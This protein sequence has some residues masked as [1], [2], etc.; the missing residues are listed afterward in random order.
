MT[1]SL[2]DKRSTRD[3]S[4]VDGFRLVADAYIFGYPLVLMDV[5]R[6]VATSVPHVTDSRAPVNQF[7][8]MRAFP[9]PAFTDVVSPNADT[10]YSTAWLDLSAGPM[11]LSL[12]EM[13]DRYYVMPLLDAWTNVF[14]CPGTRTTGGR[15]SDFVITG[16]QWSGA[17]HH[18][19]RE[20]RS[21]TSMALLIGRT[22]TN[23]EADYDAVHAIQDH[24]CL[25]PLSAWGT[26]RHAPTPLGELFTDPA[27]D[28]RTP[29][30]E[31]VAKMDGATFFSKLNALM[32]SNRPAPVDAAAIERFATIG[33]GP[34]KPLDA[35]AW[36]PAFDVGARNGQARIIDE[37]AKPQ[38]R[39]VNGWD[40]PP[41][42]LGRFGTEYLLR[43]VIALV[44]LGAN[45]PEDAVYPHATRDSEGRPLSGTKK[46]IVRFRKGELPPVRAFWS[47]TM[48]DAKQR[49]VEN[50]IARYAIGDRD[51]LAFDSDGSVT[52]FIQHDSPG[53]EH[54]SNWLPAPTGS[55]NLVMRLYWPEKQILAGVWQPPPVTR[56]N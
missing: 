14:A 4:S 56:V 43:S 24:Y 5:T 48:Y 16:P 27:A 55:F 33:V 34:G 49:V 19:M 12:P 7:V 21:P 29:P 32:Q 52:L 1:H 38:G 10:L 23:G 35:E 39:V 2:R 22:K 9:D 41:A 31:Q 40:I 13:G 8:H 11:V 18:G 45:L 36:G 28:T 47:V 46:Y 53:K 17:L 6:R 26:L 42:N 37:S 30:A 20:I 54:E 50:P 51:T 15:R 25:T 3:G 44:G